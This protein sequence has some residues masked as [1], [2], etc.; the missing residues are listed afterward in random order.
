MHI[1]VEAGSKQQQHDVNFK[2][3]WV[4]ASV[5]LLYL[6]LVRITICKERKTNYWSNCV[7]RSRKQSDASQYLQEESPNKCVLRLGLVPF[8]TLDVQELSR[9]LL[10]Q[11]TP[12]ISKRVQASLIQWQARSC[13]M[14][15][16]WNG[17]TNG[18]RVVK[19]KLPAENQWKWI[20]CA[21]TF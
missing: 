17:S 18:L 15:A 6:L 13:L 3:R 7:R 2:F 4:K 19:I 16:L 20:T 14:E 11:H 21:L 10:E 12:K 9:M 5:K 8:D 1:A